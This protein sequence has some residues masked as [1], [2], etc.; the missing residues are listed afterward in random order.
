MAVPKSTQ[1]RVV[2]IITYTVH[3]YTCFSHYGHVRL[4]R[5][6]TLVCPMYMS[7]GPYQL[8]DDDEKVSE[9]KQQE[10]QYVTC[11]YLNASVGMYRV[12]DYPYY[13][14][15]GTF[16]HCHPYFNFMQMFF[17]LVT[18]PFFTLFQ[19]LHQHI[20]ASFCDSISKRYKND[21]LF[22]LVHYLI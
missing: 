19:I 2:G 5:L 10:F 15:L 6:A 8:P 18:I 11:S 21:H 22:L 4:P 20:Y 12:C 16:W 17:T 9:E 7:D 14:C 3:P 1:T 13:S